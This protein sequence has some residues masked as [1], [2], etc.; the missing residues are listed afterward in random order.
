MRA[1]P[2]PRIVVSKCLGF[3]SCRWNGAMIPDEF[4]GTLRR[5][6]EFTAVCPELEIGLGV[7]RNPVRVVDAKGSLRL[8]QQGTERDVTE[9]MMRYADGLLSGLQPVDG[10]ILKS[11]SPSCGIKDTRIYPGM[12]KVAAMRTSA[13]IFG[14]EVLRRFPSLA[15]EDE[16]RLINDRI[17]DHFLKRV[18]A[19][20]RFR[21]LE[22]T[23]RIRDLV[24][25]QSEN[26]LLLL[27]YSQKELRAMGHIAA[28]KEGRPIEEVRDEYAKHLHKAMSRM[29]KDAA[30][31]NVLMHMLGF[32]SDGLSGDEKAFFL[33]TVQKYRLER[34]P[35]SVPLSLIRSWAIRFDQKYL[36]PQSFLEPY[37][38]ELNPVV[39]RGVARDLRP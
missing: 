31:V 29:P 18:F 23:A 25:F 5:F 17:R 32:V 14:A 3:D 20:A 16:G 7:P 1:F 10:F 22:P 15:I 12:E 35:L 30:N 19:F 4:V 27:A 34:L 21:E 9:D 28:N 8:V 2:R 11:R 36:L 13:G 24:Q 26:K 38:D 6:V 37:P 33:D 39:G